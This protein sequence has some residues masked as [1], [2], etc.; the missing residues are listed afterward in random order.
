MSERKR[1]ERHVGD[2]GKSQY[3]ISGEA[4]AYL[5]VTTRTIRSMIAD[6]RLRAYSLGSR[7]IRL[8]LDEVDAAM[9]PMGPT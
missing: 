8:R 2:R 6:G 7:M 1:T 9:Q 3:V 4:A 5:N